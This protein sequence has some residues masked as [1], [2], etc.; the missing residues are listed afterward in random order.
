MARCES[1][2]YR[3]HQNESG[4]KFPKEHKALLNFYAPHYKE[5]ICLAAV[6]T[7]SSNNGFTNYLTRGNQVT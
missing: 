3:F 5:H 2:Q 4:C 7:D 6:F 1:I